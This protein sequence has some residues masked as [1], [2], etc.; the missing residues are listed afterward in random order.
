MCLPL[1]LLTQGW[2]GTGRASL[3]KP[4][5]GAFGW[6]R[7]VSVG[8]VILAQAMSSWFV[9]SSPILGSVLTAQCLL[10][11][12][13]PPRT[14]GPLLQGRA[15]VDPRPVHVPGTQWCRISAGEGGEPGKEQGAAGVGGVL[16]IRKETPCGHPRPVSLT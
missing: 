9:R 2:A 7:Q 15:L 8:L 3:K 13:S 4:H 14:E 6:L 10:G 5:E 16:C 1:L 11:M 12:L